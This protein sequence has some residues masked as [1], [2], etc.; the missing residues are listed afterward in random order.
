[1]EIWLKAS[2]GDVNCFEGNFGHWQDCFFA[3]KPDASVE[4]RLKQVTDF[5]DREG[6]SLEVRVSPLVVGGSMSGDAVECGHVF[7]EWYAYDKYV[8]E[9]GI[10]KFR[11]HRECMVTGCNTKQAVADLQPVGEVHDITKLAPVV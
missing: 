8:F 11:Y 4:Q 9:M 7:G 1:M 2:S 5:C 6:W 10:T 3:F